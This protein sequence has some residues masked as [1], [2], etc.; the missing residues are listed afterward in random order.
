MTYHLTAIIE[1]TIH[2]YIYKIKETSTYYNK[3]NK[4][5]R[6]ITQWHCH[7]N[8]SFIHGWLPPA[9][10]Q[11][12]QSILLHCCIWN[13][14]TQKFIHSLRE[15][16]IFLTLWK[17]YIIIQRKNVILC[18]DNK[19]LARL[20]R[21]NFFYVRA[22]LPAIPTRSKNFMQMEVIRDLSVSFQMH[23]AA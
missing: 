6:Y 8:F 12:R 5:F 3:T 22:R 11:P 16:L 15:F 17:Y 19:N 10:A 2:R 1:P 14:I 4:L 9:P 21:F 18:K 7:N 13:I 23:S 20:Y